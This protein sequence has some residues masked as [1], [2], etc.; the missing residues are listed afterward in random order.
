M[1]I[2]NRILNLL[3]D[4]KIT[5]KQF[6]ADLHIPLTTLNGYIRN[7]REPDYAMIISIAR[8]LNVTV[9]YLVGFTNIPHYKFFND[10]YDEYNLLPEEGREQLREYMTFLRITYL[11]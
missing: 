7:Y 3:N 11:S 10:L 2:G 1:D 4:K 6:A 9:D 8:L 5:Q